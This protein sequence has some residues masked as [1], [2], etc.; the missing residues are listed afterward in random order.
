MSRYVIKSNQNNLQFKMEG[1]SNTYSIQIV[2]GFGF[3]V[4]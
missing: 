4:I 1:V 2:I 3:L